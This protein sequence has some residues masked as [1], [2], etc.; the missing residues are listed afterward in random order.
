M[1]Y[2]RSGDGNSTENQIVKI[3]IKSP[4]VGENEYFDSGLRNGAKQ[5]GLRLEET[6]RG[7]GRGTTGAAALQADVMFR[8][9]SMLPICYALVE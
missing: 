9:L 7:G 8:I 1:A 5:Y 3:H 2:Q 6:S 4:L